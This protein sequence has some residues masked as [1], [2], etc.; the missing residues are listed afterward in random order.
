MDIID[1]I[2]IIKNEYVFINDIKT[3]NN[4]TDNFD[5]DQFLIILGATTHSPEKKETLL[6]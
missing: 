4:N 2:N 1:N 6:E 3:T 5:D